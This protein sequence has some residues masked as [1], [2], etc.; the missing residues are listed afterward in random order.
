MEKLKSEIGTHFQSL[1]FA[2]FNVNG[3]QIIPDLHTHP[4]TI[5]PLVW[6]VNCLHP[7]THGGGT[8]GRDA[9]IYYTQN[10][11]CLPDP[12]VPL[13][14]P[15]LDGLV[16]GNSW[17]LGLMNSHRKISTT[18]SQIPFWA[19]LIWTTLH[20][21]MLF[22]VEAPHVIPHQ[23]IYFWHKTPCGLVWTYPVPRLCSKE[24]WR[25]PSALKL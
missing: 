21:L 20:C 23:V 15:P 3:P 18:A 8:G 7:L 14:P 16:G 9:W 12:G 1:R 5:F 24:N 17:H 10:S 22:W 25:E 19:V 6:N 13:P 4:C 2:R 11:E